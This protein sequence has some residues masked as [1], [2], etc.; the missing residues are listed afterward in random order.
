MNNLLHNDPIPEI[1]NNAL[2]SDPTLIQ[3][4][5]ARTEFSFPV[6][7]SSLDEEQNIEL[8]IKMEGDFGYITEAST[9]SR[10][11]VEEEK[12]YVKLTQEEAKSLPHDLVLGLLKTDNTSRDISFKKFDGIDDPRSNNLSPDMLFRTHDII[13]AIE[14]GTSITKSSER[15]AKEKLSKYR[16]IM[17]ERYPATRFKLFAIGLTDTAISS[18]ILLSHRLIARLSQAYKFGCY[19]KDKIQKQCKL[20]L[21]ALPDERII[22]NIKRSIEEFSKNNWWANDELSCQQVPNVPEEILK[23]N[24][25]EDLFS[26]AVKESVIE[27]LTEFSKYSKEETAEFFKEEIRSQWGEGLEFFNSAIS[28]PFIEVEKV[29]SDYSYVSALISDGPQKNDLAFS[30]YDLWSEVNKKI[31]INPKHRA[32]ESEPKKTEFESMEKYLKN[33]KSIKNR[34]DSKD[35]FNISKLENIRHPEFIVETGLFAKKHSNLIRETVVEHRKIKS[36]KGY[37]IDCNTKSIKRFINSYD[38]LLEYSET[39]NPTWEKLKLILQDSPNQHKIHFEDYLQTRLSKCLCFIE[40]LSTE[41]NLFSRYSGSD[42]MFLTYIRSYNLPLIVYSTGSD[43]HVF[44]SFLVPSAYLTYEGGKGLF[45]SLIKINNNLYSSPI[46]STRRSDLVQG[47]NVNSMFYSLR[48]VFL[49]TSRKAILGIGEKQDLLFSL[50]VYLENKEETCSAISNIRY[51]YQKMFE[52]HPDPSPVLS[53]FPQIIRSPLLMFAL[54]GIS[55]VFPRMIK[56]K[57][58]RV[59]SKKRNEFWNEDEDSNEIQTDLSEDNLSNTLSYISKEEVQNFSYLTN[60]Y[61][62]SMLRNKDKE[63]KIHGLSKILL[64]IMKEELKLRL[65]EKSR[66]TVPLD[67]TSYLSGQTNLNSWESHEFSCSFMYDL[68]QIVKKQIQKSNKES[69]IGDLIY[70]NLSRQDFSQFA[71]LKASAETIKVHVDDNFTGKS[72]PRIKTTEAVLR[73]MNKLSDN[74]IVSPFEILNFIFN[75][76]MEENGGLIVNIFKKLQVQGTREIFVMPIAG[77]IL[78]NLIENVSRTLC[79]IMPNEF[80]SKGREKFNH[81]SEHFSKVS[82]H[83]NPVDYRRFDLTISGDATTWCQRFVMPIFGVFLYNILKDID[84]KLAICILRVLDLITTKKLEIPDDLLN[85][86]LKNQGVDSITKPELNELKK[87]FL[88]RVKES[89]LCNHNSRYLKNRSNMMQGVLHFSSSLIHSA[90]MLWLIKKIRG[91]FKNLFPKDCKIFLTSAVTSDDSGLLATIL[92]PKE[93]QSSVKLVRTFSEIIK[94]DYKKTYTLFAMKSSLEKSTY[95]CTCGV[96]EF[97]SHWFVRNTSIN[98]LI[99]GTIASSQIRIEETTLARMHTDFGL[100][101]SLRSDGS[102]VLHLNNVQM[103]QLV[104]HYKC[105]GLHSQENSVWE[106]IILDILYLKHPIS[107]FYIPNDPLF[108]GM[109]KVSFVLSELCDK[110]SNTRKVEELANRNREFVGDEI[111]YDRFNIIL[112]MGSRRKYYKFLKSCGIDRIQV[113]EKITTS[114]VEFFLGQLDQKLAIEYKSISSSVDRGFRTYSE[115]SA[116]LPGAYMWSRVCL[117]LSSSSEVC[118]CNG[119]YV[120]SELKKQIKDL[121]FRKRLN[122]TTLKKENFSAIDEEFKF[123]KENYSYRVIETGLVKR[124]KLLN[125]SHAL[126]DI[127]D[128]VSLFDVCSYFWMNLP[129]RHPESLLR[130][131]FSRYRDQYSWLRENMTLSFELFK[132][133]Y[134]EQTDIIRFF[135]F[136]KQEIIKTARFSIITSSKVKKNLRDQIMDLIS[137]DFGSYKSLEW[138]KEDKTSGQ[139]TKDAMT[140][141]ISDIGSLAISISTIPVSIFTDCSDEKQIDF[142][143][144]M[145]WQQTPVSKI[146]TFESIIRGDFANIPLSISRN[147]LAMAIL[148]KLNGPKLILESPEE[149]V[150]YID[151]LRHCSEV[152]HLWK[153]RD[154]TSDAYYLRAIMSDSFIELTCYIVDGHWEVHRVKTNSI[155]K[156]KMCSTTLNNLLFQN[157]M[158][159]G[160]TRDYGSAVLSKEGSSKYEIKESGEGVKIIENSQLSFYPDRINFT[161]KKTEGNVAIHTTF[162]DDNYLDVLDFKSISQIDQATFNMEKIIKEDK[163][164]LAKYEKIFGTEPSDSYPN[165]TLTDEHI[166]KEEYVLKTWAEDKSVDPEYFFEMLCDPAYSDWLKTSFLER[167]EGINKLHCRN[168]VAKALDKIS[169]KSS[170]SDDNAPKIDIEAILA[171]IRAAPISDVTLW[172]KIEVDENEIDEDER[173][174]LFDLGEF[175]NSI[176]MQKDRPDYSYLMYTRKLSASRFWDKTI[177]HFE[178]ESNMQFTEI[179]EKG[180]PYSVFNDMGYDANSIKLAVS[181]FNALFADVNLQ[182]VNEAPRRKLRKINRVS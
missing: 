78:I 124:K 22:N 158:R 77:R 56:G 46:L 181:E 139:I 155:S 91:Q 153:E 93:D 36:Q 41:V 154:P 104:N 96:Y 3:D 129:N 149:V 82:E 100:T 98:P 182:F 45:K 55:S 71:T 120:L 97:N 164:L 24:I 21:D 145:I 89:D 131:A 8:T 160:P 64:K 25:H 115:A 66:M 37:S 27:N 118:K 166:I 167:L 146:I 117:V 26:E 74:S 60:L 144:E 123:I 109:S 9:I 58:P 107:W 135:T 4:Y 174:A 176:S 28:Y 112:P 143:R 151:A 138:I 127:T 128:V 130:F 87:Q 17:M 84:E 18:N 136:I 1:E 2:I 80:L 20:K 126:N 162:T 168:K 101:Q 165:M 19:L 7:S 121:S 157:Q 47:V 133:I 29:P 172:Q 83:Y 163:D 15:L 122:S 52:N 23:N 72:K 161:I 141:Q 134:G 43:K 44:Y 99:K 111:E 103:S 14:I 105:I 50:L 88:G 62:L 110:N 38:A 76:M 156:L 114:E 42:G 125:F 152:Y 6:V 11:R 57:L 113:G 90:A 33:E 67:L 34:R 16:D 12:I 94:E 177:K 92:I 68:A 73:I 148:N 175:A 31:S 49:E 140:K 142:L 59:G 116:S 54:Q 79:N 150:E 95:N 69:I 119:Y 53:K 51:L 30:Y 171:A 10:L 35:S 106:K 32:P 180:I 102:S 159:L 169:I 85:M 108:I 61:Y 137:N 63:E 170:K 147:L 65:T 178:D 5:A 75:D 70:K 86:F 39:S 81:V 179:W 48:S 132:R 40:A 13:I 173:I